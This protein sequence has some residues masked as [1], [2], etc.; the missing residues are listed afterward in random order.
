MPI[1]VK[2]TENESEMIKEA[3]AYAKEA[4]YISIGDTVIIGESDTYSK[5]N[6]LGITRTKKV[7]GIYII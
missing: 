5:T 3:I 7:G 1:L 2:E 4:E 6:N